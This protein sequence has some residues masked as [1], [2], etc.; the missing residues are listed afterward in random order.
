MDIGLVMTPSPYGTADMAQGVERMGFASLVCTDNRD[1][2]K[3]LKVSRGPR[4][5]APTMRERVSYN[6]PIGL[7]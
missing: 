1:R 3:K 5:L 4:Y 7:S 2:L 6:R